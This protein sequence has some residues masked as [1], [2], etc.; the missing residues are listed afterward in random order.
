M[1]TIKLKVTAGYINLK[2]NDIIMIEGEANYS[3]IYTKDEK[4][5]CAKTLKKYESLL[6]EAQFVRVHKSHLIN[7]K[8]ISVY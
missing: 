3:M 4:F 8:Y 1:K 6:C 7:A 2:C 5:F